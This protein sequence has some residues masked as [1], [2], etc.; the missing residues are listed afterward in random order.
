MYLAA[1]LGLALICIIGLCIVDL[2]GGSKSDV[3]SRIDEL[4]DWDD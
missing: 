3:A 1:V 2:V 4:D